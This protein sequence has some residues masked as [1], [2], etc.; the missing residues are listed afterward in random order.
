VWETPEGEAKRVN[1]VGIFVHPDHRGKGF[2]THLLKYAKVLLKKSKRRWLAIPDDDAGRAA[3]ATVGIT[4]GSKW[5]EVSTLDHYN[6]VFWDD[7]D[8]ELVMSNV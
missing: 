4:D 1:E 3:Y 5:S 7:D 8:K 6:S 2:S